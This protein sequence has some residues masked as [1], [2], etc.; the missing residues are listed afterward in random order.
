MI[1]TSVLI[2][3]QTNYVGPIAPDIE[4]A[5]VSGMTFLGHL[6]CFEE[7]Y[8][9]FVVMLIILQNIDIVVVGYNFEVGIVN[10]IPLVNQLLYGKISIVELKA[11]GALIGLI[12]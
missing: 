5:G 10:T 8:A 2:V 11:Q 9:P 1:A 6:F 7:L 3:C 4:R 12:T